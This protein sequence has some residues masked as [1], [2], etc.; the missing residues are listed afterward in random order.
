MNVDLYERIWMWGVAGMLALFFGSTAAAALGSQI[1]PP[2]HIETIDPRTVLTGPRF[3]RQ[4]VTVDDRGRVHATV[5]GLMFTWLPTEL[6]LPADTPVTF[7]LTSPDVIHGFQIVRTNGQAMVV[8]G[9]VS[10][11]TTR[12]PPGDYLVACNEYCGVG[13]H[14]MAARLRVVPRAQWRPPTAEATRVQ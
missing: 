11:F 8:P 9:Y 4:G 14:L 10:Q 6:S 2:S 5:V 1:H 13:H 7:H 12:F 3:G